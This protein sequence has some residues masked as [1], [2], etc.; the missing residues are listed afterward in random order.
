MRHRVGVG[1]VGWGDAIAAAILPGGIP[2]LAAYE[3]LAPSGSQPTTATKTNWNAVAAVAGVGLAAL[4]V[5]GIAA[6][7][8]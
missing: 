2:A 3:A 5:F 6:S 4:V 1:A 7:D 8:R